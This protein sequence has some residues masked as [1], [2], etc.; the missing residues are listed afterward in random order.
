MSLRKDLQFP[1]SYSIQIEDENKKLLEEIKNL[2]AGKE[3]DGTSTHEAELRRLKAENAVLQKS[4]K[5]KYLEFS[6]S[7]IELVGHLFCW[8]GSCLTS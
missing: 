2:K 1:T 5:C 8:S 7:T 6:Q 4:L 3:G